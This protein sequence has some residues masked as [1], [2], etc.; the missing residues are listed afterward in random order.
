VH[1]QSETIQNA[2]G[3]WINVY[4][5]GTPQAGQQLPGTRTHATVE[6]AVSE[7]QQRSQQTGK[8]DAKALL[9][10]PDFKALPQE[11]RDA[12]LRDA[13][14]LTPQASSTAGAVG[15]AVGQFAQ[16]ANEGLIGA[17]GFPFAS[18]E[19]VDA[20]RQVAPPI[21]GAE[22]SAAG[23][24]GEFVGKSAAVAVPAFGAARAA[25]AIKNS[26]GA[27]TEFGAPVALRLIDWIGK[28][29]GNV[30]GAKTPLQVAGRETASAVAGGV[31]GVA[32]TEV[33]PD[34]K[35]AELGGQLIGALGPEM[36]L[37]GVKSLW[38]Q[39]SG[40]IGPVSREGAQKAVGTVLRESIP[41]G[42]AAEAG[43]ER[44]VKTQE[45]TGLAAPVAQA[46]GAPGVKAIESAVTSRYP[47]VAARTETRRAASSEAVRERVAAAPGAEGSVPGSQATL[48][49]GLNAERA[50]AKAPVA[51]AEAMREQSI[52]HFSQTA[53]D[54]EAKMQKA[55]TDAEQEG[56]RLAASIRP[57]A[58]GEEVGDQIQRQVIGPARTRMKDEADRLYA[59]VDPE[60]AVHLPL[61]NIEAAVARARTD[62][63]G[64]LVESV[65]ALDRLEAQI[66]KFKAAAEEGGVDPAVPFNTVRRW[67]SALG[68]ASEQALR[69][70]EPNRRVSRLLSQV[71]ESVQATLDDVVR[72]GPADVAERYAA[73]K[74]FFSQYA[75]KFLTG[76]VAKV[77]QRSSTGEEFKVA[78]EDVGKELFRAPSSK[79]RIRSL[80]QYLEAV[81]NEPGAKA[82]LGD[83]ALKDFFE[84]AY[85]SADGALDPK[86]A[87]KW[88]RDHRIQLEELT[89][90]GGPDLVPEITTLI[91]KR[92]SVEQLREIS[93]QGRKRLERGELPQG[94]NPVAAAEQHL[95]HA[96]QASK[97]TLEE[98]DRSAAAKY[99]GADPA[100][101]GRT[102]L[103]GPNPTK[104]VS[105]VM[106]AAR[107]DVAAERGIRRSLLDQALSASRSP[108][109]LATG[110][111]LFDTQGFGTFLNEHRG[112]LRAAFGDE[113]VKYLEAQHRIA[114]E[115]VAPSAART[116]P[117]KM[118]E[119]M[120]DDALYTYNQL[121]GRAYQA[122]KGFIAKTFLVG[123]AFAR[124]TA[125]VLNKFS[126]AEMKSIYEQSLYDP[127]VARELRMMTFKNFV[128][129]VVEQKLRAHLGPTL[130]PPLAEAA[131]SEAQRPAGP[132]GPMIL[133]YPQSPVPQR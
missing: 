19:F 106:S 103:G 86:T 56:N 133:T 97:R 62:Q 38:K 53:Q 51:E 112:P 35:I 60:D 47:D 40:G 20:Y 69:G 74:S 120:G 81:G 52:H 115:V 12:V 102:M 113:G 10:D 23:R 43:L 1:E 122:G 125:M 117:T 54:V 70:V 123:E 6:S 132:G 104:A 44:A 5:R 13:G 8:I 109:A 72:T 88:L 108:Q 66:A 111:P 91:Q 65:P 100:L 29:M 22:D 46:T 37:K 110:N 68:D 116:S 119:G 7:A 17:L 33:F 3:Q 16:R 9:N 14:L 83:V 99:V 25:Q 121:F 49:Q 98:I 107:G 96:E 24:V 34:S 89:R 76:V 59:L 101:A 64:A 42:T 41:E 127:T 11:R 71:G 131:G 92:Q 45:Q 105:D 27:V 73:A 78:A 82:A 114:Q 79:G 84:A 75:D 48:G 61:S 18:K 94:G 2:Q 124:K 26:Y 30:G 87:M 90:A 58:T 128:P 85:K 28:A 15:T 63:A 77:L 4:G 118:I 93:T 55:V 57:T 130:A 80:D 31:G 126:D 32:A 36:A 39:V 50:A 95:A 21:P 129:E 67:A